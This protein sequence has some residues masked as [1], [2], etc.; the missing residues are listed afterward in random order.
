MRQVDA[1]NAADEIIR[2][3]SEV[4]RRAYMGEGWVEVDSQKLAELIAAA[5]LSLSFIET[6]S[7]HPSI[8]PS[9]VAQDSL[10]DALRGFGALV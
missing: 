4:H 9:T 2:R 5:L 3:S 8:H 7:Y 10:V 1:I 6:V